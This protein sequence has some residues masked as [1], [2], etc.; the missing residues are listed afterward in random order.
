MNAWSATLV[1]I[2]FDEVWI[3]GKLQAGWSG[4]LFTRAAEI[5]RYSN[6]GWSNN[7]IA[8]FESMLRN[9]YLPLVIDGWT[10]GA[11][12]LMLFA[13]TTIEIG[14]FLN[15]RAVFDTGIATWRRMAPTTIYHANDGPLPISPAS[16]LDTASELTS[17]WQNTTRF[18]T[19]LQQ[20]TLRD[21]SHMTMG[22]GSLANA[23]ETAYIQGIDLYGEQA[24]RILAGFELNAGYVNAYLDETARLGGKPPSTWTPP[25]WPGAAGTFKD[26]NSVYQS[27]WLVAQ[28]HY[29]STG[30]AMPE[31]TRLVQRLGNAA[32]Q[33]AY[34]MTWETLTHNS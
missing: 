20:E 9:V 27:G 23:A 32:T 8:R 25:N 19:G 2:K 29:T 12:W 33:P 30:T 4:T 28:H 18:I 15:D 22:L 5:I 16:Y 13:E 24:P 17:Y 7:D 1:E 6:A 14:V 21:L 34:Q 26:I 3:N 10:Q 31:T 11:N